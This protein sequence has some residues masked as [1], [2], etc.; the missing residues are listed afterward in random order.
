MSYKAVLSLGASDYDLIECTSVS[1][2]SVDRKGRP[3]SGVRGG[4]I[5]MIVQ[6]TDEETIAKW[7]V[8][9]T[10]KMDGKITFYKIW[11]QD[12]KFREIEFKGAYVINFMESFV[13]DED[14]W[15]MNDEDAIEYD[16]PVRQR[17][18][19]RLIGLHKLLR[20]NYLFMI[21]ISAEKFTID[22]IE[23]DNNW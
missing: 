17:E 3:V 15:E 1:K 16:N 10:K 22:G 2:Q 13:A 18:N 12:S 20:M 11:D 14:E 6:G 4:I 21:W 23:H 9:K 7:S 19:K 8:D 5:R